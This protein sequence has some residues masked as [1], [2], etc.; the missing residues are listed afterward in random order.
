MSSALRDETRG[1]AKAANDTRKEA[2]TGRNFIS[3][4]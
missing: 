3:A 2:A 4:V 1:M